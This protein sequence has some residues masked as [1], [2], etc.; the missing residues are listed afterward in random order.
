[1]IERIE[2]LAARLIPWRKWIIVAFLVA[3]IGVMPAT[4]GLVVL[5][6]KMWIFHIVIFLAM[7]GFTWTSGLFMI[8]YWYDPD[9]GRLTLK[10][11]M[12]PIPWSSGTG[13]SCDT[14][15]PFFW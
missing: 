9:S 8:S 13:I 1:M 3:F 4:F 5:F 10:K 12:R 7:F 2:Q 6:K 14:I 11:S 15:L